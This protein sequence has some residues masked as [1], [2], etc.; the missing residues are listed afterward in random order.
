MFLL[1]SG[2]ELTVCFWLRI[3]FVSPQLRTE[4]RSGDSFVSD[5]N[6]VTDTEHIFAELRNRIDSKCYFRQYTAAS[7]VVPWEQTANLFEGIVSNTSLSDTRLLLTFVGSDL[8]K[9]FKVGSGLKQVFKQGGVQ[10]RSRTPGYEAL[11]LVEREAQFD[12]FLSTCHPS[13]C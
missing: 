7:T 6:C 2:I 5:L 12:R 11:I 1:N 3:G 10:G 4:Y 8:K 13:V 9:I